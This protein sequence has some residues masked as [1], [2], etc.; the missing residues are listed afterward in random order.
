M[1]EKRQRS[2]TWRRCIDHPAA[3]PISL[4]AQTLVGKAG[5][6]G[7]GAAGLSNHVAPPAFFHMRGARRG[8]RAT[9]M[10]CDSS[11]HT[12]MLLQMHGLLHSTVMNTI[13]LRRMSEL[14]P[15]QVASSRLCLGC[16]RR[17][18]ETLVARYLA[19]PPAQVTLVLACASCKSSRKSSCA[20]KSPALRLV[21]IY[22]LEF[23]PST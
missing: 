17:H 3:T 22:R 1:K 23:R 15:A 19:L 6:T 5:A 21:Y 7:D 4:V 16:L 2:P 13:R 8:L 18:D 10:A 20:A 12:A 11:S 14:Y 9:S